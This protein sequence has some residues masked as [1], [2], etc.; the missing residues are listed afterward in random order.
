MPK[1]DTMRKPISDPNKPAKLKGKNFRM[2]V[3]SV[4]H[5]LFQDLYEGISAIEGPWEDLE[6][7]KRKFMSFIRGWKWKKPLALLRPMLRFGYP[8]RHYRLLFVAPD[9]GEPL[10]LREGWLKLHRDLVLDESVLFLRWSIRLGLERVTHRAQY[11]WS[12]ESE[13]QRIPR[14]PV[15]LP[16]SS[17]SFRTPVSPTLG[18]HMVSFTGTPN[19]T[20]FWGAALAWEV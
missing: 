11:L 8:G 10:R 1:D 16:L 18:T 19:I 3:R 5:S 20:P 15:S 4:D 9:E 2:G 6:Y 12:I 13:W 14:N 7:R 17:M